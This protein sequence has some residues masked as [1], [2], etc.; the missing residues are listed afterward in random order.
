MYTM[1]QTCRKTDMTYEALKFYC[2]EGL[3]PNVKRDAHNHRVFDD[4]DVEWIRS[5]TC[6][7]SCGM[8]IREMKLY[9]GLCQQGEATIPERKRILSQKREELLRRMAELQV[10]VDFI[11]RKQRLYDDL[12]AGKAGGEGGPRRTE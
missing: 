11:D 10:S 7:K 5:L 1:K 4:R 9:I 8:S 3:V 12:L 2:N 6:L